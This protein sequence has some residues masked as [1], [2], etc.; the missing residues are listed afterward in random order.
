[1]LTIIYQIILAF[2]IL[3]IVD[4]LFSQKKIL[5]Q[6][7]AAFALIPFILRLFMIG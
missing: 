7:T 5:A 3:L 2:V 4:E 1:M 6:M